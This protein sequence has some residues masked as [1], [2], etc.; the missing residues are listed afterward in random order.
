MKKLF[1]LKDLLQEQLRDLYDAEVHYG[2]MLGALI[3]TATSAD[4]EERLRHIAIQTQENAVQLANICNL[5]GVPPEG[6]TCKA[7]DGLLREA[8]E[9]TQDWGD[10]ATI[11][12]A[13]IANAQRIVHY[14][15]AGFGTAREFAK[16]LGEKETAS[17]LNEILIRSYENDKELSSI[18][19]GKWFTSGINKES[20]LVSV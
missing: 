6:V 4:L 19:K 20:A 9:T 1:G 15:I 14:E 2:N 12:A 3:K 16:C 18:A 13:L 5:L 10:S 11:D 8:K 17:I 7:M